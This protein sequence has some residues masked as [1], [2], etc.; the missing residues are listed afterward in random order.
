MTDFKEI[1]PFQSNFLDLD[2]LK[3]HYLDEGT[4]ANL[5]M[6]HGN[7]TWSFYYRNLILG[8][9]DEYRVLAPDHIGC[10]LSDK[11]Q[12]YQYS[13]ARHIANLEIFTEKLQ[14]K[15]I[16]LVI[17]D[18]GGA[19]GMGFAVKHPELIKRFVVFNTAAFLMPQIHLLLK[20]CRIPILGTLAIRWFNAFAA[21][22]VILACKN[23]EKMTPQV[24][25]GYLAPYNSYANRI[26]N[27]RF[28][29]D[30]PMTTRDASYKLMQIIEQGLEQF[31]DHPMLIAW[32][33]KDFVF[34]NDFLKRWQEFFPKAQVKTFPDA[35][36]Y[37]VEDAG[38][39]I[40]PLMK[41]FLQANPIH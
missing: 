37:V 33:G 25:A 5:L 30:I 12:Q 20:I 39:E 34:N 18:W 7:P 16:T 1:Y 19:I 41:D 9:K 2:R 21:M 24:K 3:Y 14:L 4:G 26:A 8:L 31:K 32:G 6:L 35:G 36:H 29:Q 40:L 11:P 13:L 28:V 15:N 17:H 23:R 10:G 38:D 27:L 22:A